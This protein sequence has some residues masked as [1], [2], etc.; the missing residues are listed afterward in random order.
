MAEQATQNGKPV[1]KRRPRPLPEGV[2]IYRA[3]RMS[4]MRMGKVVAE[5]RSG[6]AT[7]DVNAGTVHFE[8]GAQVKVGG[9]KVTAPVVDLH[10]VS[11]RMTAEGGVRVDEEGIHLEADGLTSGPSLATMKLDG[12]V[13][14]KAKDKAVAEAL[15]KAN[16]R[17]QSG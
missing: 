15:L 10:L 13:N 14:V 6:Y 4:L 3:P 16:T 9:A 11:G 1:R 8:R 17:P 7:L 2:R 12:K 5:F